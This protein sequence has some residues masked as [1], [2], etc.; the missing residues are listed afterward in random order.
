MPRSGSSY[1]IRS[2]PAMRERIADQYSASLM[3]VAQA[4]ARC[5]YAGGARRS[6]RAEPF[7][8]PRSPRWPRALPQGG[9]PSGCRATACRGRCTCP[10]DAYM[11][12]DAERLHIITGPN[13]SGKSTYL[14]QVGCCRATRP[15]GLVRACGQGQH[16]SGRQNLTRVGAQDDLASGQS[17]FMVEMSETANILNNATV[18]RPG[19]ARRSGRGTQHLRRT[20]AC[21]GYRRVPPCLGAKSFCDPLPSAQRA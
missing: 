17:T 14:R 5:R 21:V 19:C 11:D 1:S 3:K 4:V 9:P 20:R 12:T 15:D 2:F 7:L 18:R 6:G 10:N 8:P 16:R 13:A